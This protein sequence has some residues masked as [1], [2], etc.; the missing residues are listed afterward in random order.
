MAV[1]FSGS[2]RS[3]L[4]SRSQK[5]VGRPPLP[6]RS[7]QPGNVTEQ[8][9]HERIRSVVPALVAQGI[10]QW[11]PE[12]KVASSNLAEGTFS[13]YLSNRASL[14]PKRSRGWMPKLGVEQQLLDNFKGAT[15]GGPIARWVSRAID[16][17]A[18]L[19][20]LKTA[21]SVALKLSRILHALGMQSVCHRA[22]IIWY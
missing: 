1:T 19:H 13:S 2:Q 10:E 20:E 21:K 11:F 14:R 6:G 22:G 3:E 5:S 17:V 12:P 7:E 8:T 15:N 9:S 18:K 4:N 16:G